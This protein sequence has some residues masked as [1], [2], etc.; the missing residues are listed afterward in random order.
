MSELPPGWSAVTL[1]EIVTDAQ[2]GCSARTGTGTPTVVLRLADV[3]TDGSVATEGLRRIPLAE[4]D[5]NKYRLEPGDLL[6]FRVNGSRD[7]AGRVINYKGASG[8]AYCDHFIRFRVDATQA[9]SDF[10]AAAFKAPAP[11]AAVEAAMVSSAGQNTVSQGTLRAVP[12]PLPPLEEQRRIVRKLGT[13]NERSRRARDALD[14]IPP[15]LEKLRQSILAAAFRGDLTRDWRAEHTDVEPASE[16]LKRIRVERRKEWEEAELAKMVA[17]GKVPKDDRWKAKYEE[18]KPVDSTGLPELPEGWCWA[19]VEELSSMITSGSR[20]WADYYAAS[21]AR[22]IRSQDINTDHLRLDDVAYVQIPPQAEGARTRVEVADLLITITGANVTR[23]AWVDE[24]PSEA[25]VSQHVALVRPTITSLAP[26]MHLWLVAEEGGRG[27]LKK[28]AYGLGKPGLNLQDVGRVLV[29]LLPLQESDAMIARVRELSQ[30]AQHAL[31]ATGSAQRDL[32]SL[33]S[34]LLAKAFRGDLVPQGSNAEPVT[35]VAPLADDDAPGSRA[36][37]STS[38]GRVSP[39]PALDSPTSA[40]R[41]KR[42][43]RKAS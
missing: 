3:S 17:K 36:S 28:A 10:V 7:I 43:R 37:R 20:G 31:S 39:E 15:L 42:P 1:G 4:S 24:D 34:A 22:F 16:L 32:A 30:W 6:A 26:T 40:P 13:L 27:Q 19:T 18:P 11:R 33:D 12:L 14:S 38:P 29:P 9:D 25:Y 5:A 21:G 35:P 41:S 2:N 23:C 8:H